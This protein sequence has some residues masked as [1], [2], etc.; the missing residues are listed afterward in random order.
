MKL[1]VVN[2]TDD[3]VL[4]LVRSGDSAA[5]HEFYR[6]NRNKVMGFAFRF[7]KD[8]EE[9]KELTQ[10]IFVSLWEKREKIDPSKNSGALLL[11]MVRNRFLDSLKRKASQSRYIETEYQIE[12]SV[13]TTDDYINFKD[14]GEIASLAIHALPK[15]AKIIYLLSR[16]NGWSH[17]EISEHMQI[18]KKTVNNQITKS[19]RHIRG[20]FERLSPETALMAI[21]LLKSLIPG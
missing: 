1:E 9:A 18:S 7:L 20:H 11:V 17:K 6:R 16:D 8:K 5:Y 10:E 21:L 15:Q 12:P 19:L 13:S 14:C 3:Q 4:N 2:L